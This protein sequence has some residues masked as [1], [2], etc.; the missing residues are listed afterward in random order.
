MLSL[1]ALLFSL[2]KNKI[3]KPPKTEPTLCRNNR[4]VKFKPNK[5]K[6]LPPPLAKLHQDTAKLRPLK[7]L[8]LKACS[9]TKPQ[10][11]NLGAHPVPPCSRRAAMPRL[12]RD[13]ASSHPK[14]PAVITQTELFPALC[15]NFLWYFSCFVNGFP[16]SKQKQLSS[17]LLSRPYLKGAA[18]SQEHSGKYEI[19]MKLISGNF[20]CDELKLC[21]GKYAASVQRQPWQSFGVFF[22]EIKSHIAM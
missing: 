4:P 11:R 1:F 22:P 13:S 6:F 9:E 15:P 2:K 17:S 12:L 16:F 8:G 10:D 5:S 14:I 18:V 3:P 20:A 19:T 21:Y 7:L